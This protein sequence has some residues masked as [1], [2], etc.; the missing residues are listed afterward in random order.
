MTD[1]TK[2]SSSAP[3]EAILRDK[4][5]DR[6]VRRV[7]A[8]AWGSTFVVLLGFAGITAIRIAHMLE[9]VHVGAATNL[10]VIATVMP[11]VAV[12]GVLS[13]LIAVLST[14]GIFLRL[15]TA[16]LR[17]YSSGWQR[18]RTFSYGGTMH[19]GRPV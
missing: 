10:D 15:R 11:F 17:R 2:A 13:L 3:W 4:R 1:Q 19:D 14:V 7:S 16:S 6:L 5:L 18:L 9:R 12:S 8:T